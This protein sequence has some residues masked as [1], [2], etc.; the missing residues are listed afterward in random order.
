M[1]KLTALLLA[2]I[3][4]LALVCPLRP[5]APPVYSAVIQLGRL[6]L[7]LYLITEGT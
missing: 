1:K 4:T 3:M 7:S 5:D 2:L 6:L